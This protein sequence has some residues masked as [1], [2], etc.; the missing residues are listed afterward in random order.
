[1]GDDGRKVLVLA[2]FTRNVLATGEAHNA[3]GVHAVFIA[4]LGRHKAVGGQ[5]DG[6]IEGVKF[7]LLLPPWCS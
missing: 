3:R 6:A 1:M 5:Q 7:F 2:D 4:V